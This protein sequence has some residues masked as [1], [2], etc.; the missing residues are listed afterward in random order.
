M[1]VAVVSHTADPCTASDSTL[2]QQF[3]VALISPRK[4]FFPVTGAMPA[5]ATSECD[6]FSFH[7]FHGI[8]DAV[9]QIIATFM[10]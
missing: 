3:E 10:Q 7:G 2:A 4:N 9:I 5:A 1:P 6:A 8:E